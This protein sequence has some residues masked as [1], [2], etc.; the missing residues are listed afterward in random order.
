MT[1]ATVSGTADTR[2][3]TEPSRPAPGHAAVAGVVAAAAALGLSELAA[4]VLT[5]PSLIAAVGGFVIDHQHRNRVADF[6][7]RLIEPVQ[8]TLQHTLVLLNDEQH[9]L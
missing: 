4:G 3:A 7:W 5:A 9:R 2:A 8:Q 6:G 1:D